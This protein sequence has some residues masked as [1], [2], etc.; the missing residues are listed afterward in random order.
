MQSTLQ[1]GIY[2]GQKIIK[3]LQ[4]TAASGVVGAIKA[5]ASRT[6]VDFAY[7]LNKASQESGMNPLAKASSSS[8]TGLYQFIKQTW[9]QMVKQH[10]AEYG[11]GAEADAIQVKNGQ[12]VVADKALREKILNM[13][14][15][16]VLSAAMAAEFTRDN[17][18]YLE[19]SVGGNVG[20]TEL[21]LAHFLG[22]GGA[23]TFLKAMRNSPN[24]SAAD[25]LP[26]AASAN[27]SV[28]YSKSGREL[29]LKEIYDRFA[30]KFSNKGLNSLVADAQSEEAAN[31]VLFQKTAAVSS[32]RDL[33]EYSAD[34]YS[35]PAPEMAQRQQNNTTS[36]TL[37]NVMLMAQN[38]MNE[39]L[40]NF[41]GQHKEDRKLGALGS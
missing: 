21:Y 20:S 35:A 7:L 14:H 12:A 24:A 17:K 29:S 4:D 36:D 33:A 40:M 22:A 10:G 19:A 11:L 16:P 25:L 26:E 18:D 5:A 32:G 28:F 31:S 34:F 13:R 27:Q 38:S 23:S 9:L 6:G 41:T 1:A 39:S 37:F 30:S 8:A 2:N 3:G 15:D